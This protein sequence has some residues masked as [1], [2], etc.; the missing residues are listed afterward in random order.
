MIEIYWENKEEN[1]CVH[2]DGKQSKRVIISFS[3]IIIDTSR[4][5][6]KRMLFGTKR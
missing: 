6:S 3:R 1:V 5:S 4:S 2:L